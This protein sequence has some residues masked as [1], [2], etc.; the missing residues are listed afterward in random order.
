MITAMDT[1]CTMLQ[2]M[3]SS[4]GNTWTEASR[5]GY[6]IAL[7]GFD[8]ELIFEVAKHAVKNCTWRPAPAELLEMAANIASPLPNENEVFNTISNCLMMGTGYADVSE[9]VS[10]VVCAIGGWWHLAHVIETQF[11]KS[12]ISKS[13]KIEREMWEQLVKIQL[14]LPAHERSLK[15]FPVPSS[16]LAPTEKVRLEIA[17]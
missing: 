14:F 3:N 2:T 9:F 6:E 10:N 4:V 7:K 17:S 1:L 12:A 15:Y 16:H 5:L 11:L 8:D 13:Y